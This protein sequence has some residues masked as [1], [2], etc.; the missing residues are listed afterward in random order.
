MEDS[1]AIG[2]YCPA[3]KNGRALAVPETVRPAVL[4]KKVII[5]GKRKQSGQA[6]NQK[7][8]WIIIKNKGFWDA[9]ACMCARIGILG[10]LSHRLSRP[11][12]STS[13]VVSVAWRPI[14]WMHETLQYENYR[15]IREVPESYNDYYVYGVGMIESEF[16]ED[17]NYIDTIKATL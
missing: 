1:V 8:L 16:S 9:P 14:C 15:L 12:G 2:G 3:K 11:S 7:A 6:D 17:D 10:Q 4:L 13:R 5:V